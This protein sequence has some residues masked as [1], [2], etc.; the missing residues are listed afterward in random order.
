MTRPINIATIVALSLMLSVP[1]G[2]DAW[3]QSLPTKS[4][5]ADL[6][7]KA[8]LATN[9]RADDAPPFHLVAQIHY[10]LG[11]QSTEGAYEL[12]WASP[13]KYRE[14]FRMERAAEVELAAGDKLYVLRNTQGTSLPYWTVRST[15]R[16]FKNAFPG[17][18]SKI[19]KVYAD[20][21]GAELLTCMDFGEE[22]SPKQACVSPDT[23]GLVSLDSGHL[24]RGPASGTAEELKHLDNISLTEFMD[25]GE[26]R[27]PTRIHLELFDEKLEIK[28]QT[29]AQ[30][31]TFAEGL[32]TPPTGAVEYDWCSSPIEEGSKQIDNEPLLQQEPPGVAVAYYVLIGTDGRVKKWAPSSSGGKYVDEREGTRLRDAMFPIHLCGSKAIEYETVLYAPTLLRSQPK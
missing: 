19:K 32:F 28:I 3:A 13:D 12:S 20:K 31:T 16:S 17:P 11:G 14:E 30:V 9:L 2:S 24:L 26:K 18:K 10:E 21:V 15:L 8:G 7:Q 23:N 22:F 1:S 4:E 25:V 29:L 27:Y 5:A 6:L